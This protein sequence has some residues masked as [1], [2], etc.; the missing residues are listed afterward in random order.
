MPAQFSHDLN[1]QEEN[2]KIKSRGNLNAN[3]ALYPMLA[4]SVRN[5]QLSSQVSRSL[6]C[7]TL[8]GVA[9]KRQ[10]TPKCWEKAK[11]GRWRTLR[12]VPSGMNKKA[13]LS[14][15]KHGLKTFSQQVSFP[16]KDIYCQA[17]PPLSSRYYDKGCARGLLSA[18]AWRPGG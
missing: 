6:A 16:E 9:V 15:L 18:S 11:P 10:K 7:P 14:R 17:L 3:H 13:L 5:Q 12:L 2:S 8:T 1:E 4:N